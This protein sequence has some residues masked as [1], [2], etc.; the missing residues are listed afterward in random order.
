MGKKKIPGRSV[1]TGEGFGP[2]IPENRGSCFEGLRHPLPDQSG[3]LPPKGIPIQGLEPDEGHLPWMIPQKVAQ[4]KH[5]LET[6]LVKTHLSGVKVGR[7]LFVSSKY[8][9][10]GRLSEID[11]IED[12]KPARRLD[13]RHQQESLSSSV[14]ETN[15][16]R[17]VIGPSEGFD[18]PNAKPFVGPKQIPDAENKNPPRGRLIHLPP[19]VYFRKIRKPLIIVLTDVC[20]PTISSL[21]AMYMCPTTKTRMNH[22]PR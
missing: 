8:H 22:I 19:P 14:H 1:L 11:R 3:K 7:N 20:R 17:K 16:A 2:P 6:R 21:T 5:L 4:D 9:R 10:P 15:G 12:Q 18:R 13:V